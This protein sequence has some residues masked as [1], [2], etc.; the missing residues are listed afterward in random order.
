ME[1]TH[2]Q[3]EVDGDGVALNHA[4]AGRSVMFVT[5]PKSHTLASSP[6]LLLQVLYLK[7]RVDWPNALVD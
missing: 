7:I 5:P 1:L 2:F 6:Y 4:E 3:F